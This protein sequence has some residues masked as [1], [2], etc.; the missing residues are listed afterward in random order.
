MS[1]T[2][3]SLVVPVSDLDAA[4]SVYTALLGSPH[5]DQP[6]YVGYNVDGFEVSLAPGEAAADRWPTPT[7]RISTRPAQ[8][9][10]PL[11]RPSAA[12]PVKS[13][14][15]RGCACSPTPTA[16]RSACAAG[17]RRVP[18]AA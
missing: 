7:S 6:Y 3:R 1:P 10:S 15:R 4:K 11:V 18:D 13:H 12:L 17:S 9:C 2:I 8:P 16:T 14:P 5:T